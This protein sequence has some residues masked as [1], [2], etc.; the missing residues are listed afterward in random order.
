MIKMELTEKLGIWMDIM[1]SVAPGDVFVTWIPASSL[2][3][4]VGMDLTCRVHVYDVVE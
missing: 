1:T 2:P 3:E 4:S